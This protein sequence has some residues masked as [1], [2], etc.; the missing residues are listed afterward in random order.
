MRELMKISGSGQAYNCKELKCTS[1]PH[2]HI[3]GT[4]ERMILNQPQHLALLLKPGTYST[5][6]FFYQ[7]SW[8]RSFKQNIIIRHAMGGMTNAN[9]KK[10]MY[11]KG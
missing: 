4:N 3:T 5:D 9:T 6:L 7:T 8:L 10:H 11:A 1:I 2:P